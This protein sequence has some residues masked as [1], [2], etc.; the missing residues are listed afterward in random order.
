M[1]A[2]LHATSL[3]YWLPPFSRGY[4]E[5]NGKCDMDI[6]ASEEKYY[7][8]YTRKQKVSKALNNWFRSLD[9]CTPF[10]PSV[11]NINSIYNYKFTFTINI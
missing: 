8:N 6:D 4:C 1:A 10:H 9:Y 7:R 11:H 2:P 5:V 3:L